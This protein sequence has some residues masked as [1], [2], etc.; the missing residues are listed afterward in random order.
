MRTFKEYVLARRSER[1]SSMINDYVKS[2][3]T[4]K[5]EPTRKS[6]ERK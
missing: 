6:L 1:S 5:D 2:E 4:K 3:S